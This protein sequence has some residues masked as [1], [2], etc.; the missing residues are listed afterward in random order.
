MSKDHS[1]FGLLK[2]AWRSATH[3]GTVDL[4][5]LARDYRFR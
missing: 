1:K 5:G 3:S 4:V 2:G